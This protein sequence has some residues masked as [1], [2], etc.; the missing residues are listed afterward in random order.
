MKEHRFN[1]YKY[2][3][4]PGKEL[5]SLTANPSTQMFLANQT[6]PNRNL[7]PGYNYLKHITY[8]VIS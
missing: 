7:Q 8:S 5:S 1:K 6:F 3:W 2:R 4:L